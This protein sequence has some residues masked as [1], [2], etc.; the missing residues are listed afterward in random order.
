MKKKKMNL[1]VKETK[2]MARKRKKEKK[3]NN[4]IQN[5]IKFVDL[6]KSR[7]F[8]LCYI[9]IIIDNKNK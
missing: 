3:M 5:D 2:E 4:K 9:I 6:N 8:F 1:L 7:R